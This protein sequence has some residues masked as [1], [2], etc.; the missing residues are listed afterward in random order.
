MSTSATTIPHRRA[1]PRRFFR[2]KEGTG[3]DHC[4]KRGLAFAEHADLIWWETSHPNLEDAKRF[5]EA[6]QAKFPAR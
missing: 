3:V 1:H 6:I 5:A 4:I 2:L